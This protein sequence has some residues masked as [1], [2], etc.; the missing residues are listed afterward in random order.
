[1]NLNKIRSFCRVFR[2]AIG[3]GLVGYALGSGNSWFYLG[4]IPLFVGVCDVCPLCLFSKNC[5][6]NEN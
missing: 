6:I 1:M 3:A 5:D 4:V 2:T